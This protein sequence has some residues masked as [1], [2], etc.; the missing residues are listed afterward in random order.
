MT[1]PTSGI[2]G[3]DSLPTPPRVRSLILSQQEEI[4]VL[5]HENEKM[6][7]QLTAL[8]ADLASL[9]E[10][11][12]RNS[13]NSSKPPLQRRPGLQNAHPA[14]RQW[15]QA[16]WS[17][18]SSRIRAGAAHSLINATLLALPLSG[19]HGTWSRVAEA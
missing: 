9:R 6:R 13:R 15:P 2:L 3:A 10:R 19:R 7:Q 1:T 5:R 14:Q 12:G 4:R 11:I 18:G 8:A 17:A 16:G